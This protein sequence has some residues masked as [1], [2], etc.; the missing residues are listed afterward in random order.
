MTVETVLKDRTIVP[1]VD[2]L[3]TSLHSV[4]DPDH[5]VI[6]SLADLA[7]LQHAL[8]LQDPHEPRDPHK[9]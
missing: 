6:A 5:P 3:A 2:D 1:Q 7:D 4:I 8:L 9:T